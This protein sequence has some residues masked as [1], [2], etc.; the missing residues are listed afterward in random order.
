MIR[1][2]ALSKRYAGSLALDRISFSVGRG[3]IVGLL[4][5]N[6]AGK[7]T[8]LRVLTGFVPPTSGQVQVDGLDIDRDSRAIRRKIGYLPEGVPLYPELRVE[9]HLS[10][11]AGIKEIPRRRRRDAM[12]RVIELCRLGEVRERIVGQISRGFRQRL[13]LADALL[14]DPPILVLDEPTVGLDPNQIRQ[15]RELIRSLGGD[16]TVLLSTHVLPEVEA[17]CSRVLI[18]NEGQLVADRPVERLRSGEAGEGDDEAV[19]ITLRGSE[20]KARQLLGGV[21]GVQSVDL[22]EGAGDSVLR[23]R[24]RGKMGPAIREQLAQA[25]C[26]AGLALRELR[27]E[28]VTLEQV[29]SRLTADADPTS[30]EG[31][32]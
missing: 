9:E 12:D 20:D 7:T 23:F 4:G 6:G 17:T 22:L 24:L 26:A 19:V 5:P 21:E 8:C 32:E 30:E 28:G 25:V 31:P 3:E 13:G 15:L 27:G 11:R 18:I 10:F 14:G 2:E 1:V 29:F 16:H